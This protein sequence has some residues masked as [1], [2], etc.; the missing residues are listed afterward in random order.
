MSGRCKRVFKPLGHE[1]AEHPTH[2]SQLTHHHPAETAPLLYCFVPR[3]SRGDVCVMMPS[4]KQPAKLAMLLLLT[5]LLLC[6]Q[7]GNVHGKTIHEISVDLQPLLDFKKGITNDPLGALNN[8]NT[9]IHF[10]W[11]SGVN[12]TTTQPFRVSSLN[13]TGHNLEGLISSSLG[14]LTFLNTLDLSYN[15]FLG[16]IPLL[17]NLKELQTLHLWSNQL[18]GIIPDALAN[19]SNLVYLDL[20]SNH[21]EGAIPPKLDSLSNLLFLNLAVNNLTGTIP[22]N[23]G[24]ITTLQKVYLDTNQLEGT[25]PDKLWQLPKMSALSLGR[26]RLSG[27]IPKTLYNLSSLQ[28]LGLEYNMLGNVLPP[29]FGDIFPN[30]LW[31]TLNYNRFEGHIPA[32]LGNVSLLGSIDLSFNNFTGPVPSTLGMLSE[33]SFLNLQVNKLEAR[34]SQG[35]EFLHSLKNCK[36]LQTLGL[37]QNQLYGAIPNSI[38]DLSLNLQALSLSGN[39]LSGSVPPSIGN[40][41]GLINLL[42]D[43]NNLTGTIDG[44]VERLTNL[45]GLNLEHNNFTGS[46]PYSLGHLTNLTKLSVASNALEGR[47]P[48][49]LGKI[50]GLL[51]L[52]LSHNNFQGII[53][54]EI[55][56]LRQLIK[57]DLSANKLTGKIPDALD[58]C[59]NLVN[60]NLDANFLNGNIPIS[61]GNLKSLDNLNLSH[62]NLSGTIP[63]TLN[64]LLLLSK[65]DLSYNL[66]QGVIPVTGVFANA[67]VVSLEG[68]VGLCGG[69]I[70]LH[71]PPCPAVS[72]GSET[73]Y[74]LVRALIPLFGFMSLVMLT[75]IIITQKKISRR[76]NLFLLSFGKKFPRVSYKDLNQA[77]GN[78]SQAKLLGRGSYGSV[79]RGK[80]TQAKIQVAIK[81]FDLDMK[82]A[83][84]SFVTECDVLRSIRH[85]NLLPILTAC[86]TI[87][88]N[89]DAF[90]ALIYEYMPNGN[91][92]TW[93]HGKFS[94]DSSKCLSLAQRASIA[95]GIADALAYLHHDCEIQIVHCD[96][97][98]TNIL[99]DDDMN[100]Y[101]GDFGIASL[102]GHSSSNTSIG[103]KGT[104]GY[105][106]PGIVNSRTFF[107][108]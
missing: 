15:N 101:L 28:T 39:R 36:I 35:W 52:N 72:R 20:S 14:N 90:K 45:Q 108:V 91:L 104:I 55:S 75:Y 99:L 84:K 71:M 11:W 41:H 38:G 96:L 27:E 5:L 95:V 4:P 57:L 100:A 73:G 16:G 1:P 65:L 74:Y 81:V 40:L 98:P 24:N 93:L 21:L 80:L 34:D 31:L 85:R 77:T 63:I 19:C 22:P 92:D 69:V 50:S 18:R 58:Q 79:Y 26:N 8:W 86:S 46:I 6:N 62:N 102:V 60:I 33:L 32:S 54:P 82:F 87:D 7:V 68:N 88:N 43:F 97:K 64:G 61:F 107:L 10:C 83:D 67:T 13:L 78:F 94:G 44:W 70:D 25:I 51:E 56:N 66:F 49:S 30:L 9:S 42:L 59:T 103:L 53:P 17:G 29:N 12:C 47:I 76:T 105:I 3:Q 89:G 37:A 23:L 48:I 2:P 106:A